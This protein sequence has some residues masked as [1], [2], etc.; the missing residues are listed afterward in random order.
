MRPDL[1]PQLE[2]LTL[3]AEDAADG[4]S[5]EQVRLVET[6][7]PGI[8]ARALGFVEARFERVDLSGARLANLFLSDCELASCNLANAAVH[9]GSM[10]RVVVEG[11]R[12]TGL[13]W[14]AG[15]IR[16]AEFRDCRADMASFERCQLERVLFSDCD[17]RDADFR[18]VRAESLVFSRCDLSGAD[19]THAQLSGCEMSG[20][21]LDGLR[22]VD[23]LRGVAMPWPDILAA[24]GVFAGE[25]GVRVLDE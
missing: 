22:G 6:A 19:L 14:T 8:D 17:L 4:E 12:L 10:R 20:C 1:P 5:W 24:A 7:L 9:G 2:P 3:E 23:R 21:T 25:L 15:S 11:G 16:D 18:S 13:L